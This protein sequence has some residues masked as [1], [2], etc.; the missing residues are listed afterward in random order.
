LELI[1]PGTSNSILSFTNVIAGGIA[2]VRGSGGFYSVQGTTA[3]LSQNA[4][5]I[6]GKWQ[7][8]GVDIYAKDANGVDNYIAQRFFCLISTNG[9]VTVRNT[10]STTY[11]VTIGTTSSSNIILTNTAASN[12]VYNYTIIYFPVL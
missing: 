11:N 1:N 7:K 2:S 10:Y 4:T 5:A 12:V 3:S 9:S 6:I 8:G